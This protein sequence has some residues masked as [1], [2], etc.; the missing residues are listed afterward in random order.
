LSTVLISFYEDK[1]E[2]HKNAVFLTPYN[3]KYNGGKI[4]QF[5]STDD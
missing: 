5:I 3:I 2:C 1:N 4:P